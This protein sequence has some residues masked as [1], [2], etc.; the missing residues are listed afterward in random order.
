[1]GAV[2]QIFKTDLV[3]ISDFQTESG[4]AFISI[5]VT[6]ETLGQPVGS[7][8]VIVVNEG[9]H[10]GNRVAKSR[11]YDGSDTGVSL[12]NSREYTIVQLCIPTGSDPEFLYESYKTFSPND[13]LRIVEQTLDS[14]GF[15]RPGKIINT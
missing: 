15:P 4:V 6:V 14:L 8:P 10:I 11:K 13:R 1:M 2:K 3:E 12:F 5:P 9:V 7:A